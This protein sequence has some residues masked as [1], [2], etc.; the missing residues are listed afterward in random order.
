MHRPR[1]SVVLISLNA[2][3]ILADCLSSVGWADEIVVLDSGSNDNTQAIA[4][5][6]GA[7][8]FKNT[9]WPGFGK[10]R[11]LA[12]Q[13]AT[14]DYILMIDT[15][16]RIT[17][18]LRQSIEAVLNSPKKDTVYRFARSNLFLGRFMRHS[19]WYPDHVIRLYPNNYYY[20]DNDVHESLDYGKSEVVTLQ[21]DLEHL[22]CRDFFSFQEKQLMYAKSWARER[23]QKGKH[24]SY[25]AIYTHATSAFIKTWILRAGFLDGKQ[26][27]LLSIINFQYTFNKYAGLWALN[28]GNKLRNKN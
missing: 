8:F 18:A 2:E 16:E 11:Q 14:G 25:L 21:G 19:G 5:Q 27:L 15:D 22:T 10:Q 9:S 17:P 1:L 6:Y 23:F 12:Q 13:Y 28:N 26:G 3:E 24:C 20:N 7:K 4:Y